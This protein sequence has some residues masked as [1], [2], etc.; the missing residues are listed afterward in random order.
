MNGG[1]CIK[2]FIPIG[3]VA[4]KAVTESLACWKHGFAE[5]ITDLSLVDDDAFNVVINGY[6]YDSEESL[7]TVIDAYL[8]VR[9]GASYFDVDG[10]DI[11]CWLDKNSKFKAIE[12]N[13][14]MDDVEYNT[15]LIRFSI[16]QFITKLKPKYKISGLI[17]TLQGGSVSLDELEAYM[18]IPRNA[19]DDGI[20]FITNTCFFESAEEQ[21]MTL[22]F[23]IKYDF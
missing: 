5:Q 15:S 18:T 10:A 19:L 1:Q 16:E 6:D 9:C 14:N 4:R 17:L 22:Y 13:L 11:S 8:K 23:A 20:T 2:Y 12:L 21:I 3:L 7:K